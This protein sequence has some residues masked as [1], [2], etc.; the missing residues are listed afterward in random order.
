[1]QCAH[2][3]LEQS[4]QLVRTAAQRSSTH[5]AARCHAQQ[6]TILLLP[7]CVHNL[8]TSQIYFIKPNAE[9][10][11]VILPMRFVSAQ[12]AAI[13]HQLLQVCACAG[14]L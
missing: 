2:V 4:T 10:V 12:D 9:S 7:S 6:A 8:I 5:R 13:G 1:M 11:V 14:G 3:C